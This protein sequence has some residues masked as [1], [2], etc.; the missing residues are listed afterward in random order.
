MAAL[1]DMNA[2]H[3]NELMAEV[4]GAGV[5]TVVVCCCR[6]SDGAR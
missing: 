1:D 4:T 6:C 5:L 2:L 3:C